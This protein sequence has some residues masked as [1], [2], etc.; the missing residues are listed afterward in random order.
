MNRRND[1]NFKHTFA[2]RILATI[3]GVISLM[4]GGIASPAG[5]TPGDVFTVATLANQSFPY[6]IA[7]DTSGN[8]YFTEPFY[9]VVR[10]ISS[11]GVVS[12]FAGT[13]AMGANDGPVGTATFNDPEGLAVDSSGNVYV[14]DSGNH[15]IRKI[16]TAGNVTT[17]SGTGAVGSNDGAF[18]VA[19]FEGPV[20][21][22]FDGNGNLIVTSNNRIRRIDPAGTVVTI[23]GTGGYGFT[24]GFALGAKFSSPTGV[25]VDGAGNVIIADLSNNRIRKL[26]PEGMVSTLAG[27]GVQNPTDGPGATASFK[28]PYGV[29]V[30]GGGTVYVSDRGNN[31]IR[32]VLPDGTV[33]S[34]AGSGAYGVDD[35]P[36]STATFSGLRGITLR[37]GN[38]FV[39][40]S[41]GD[42]IRRIEI[43]SDTIAPTVTLSSPTNGAT[44]AASPVITGNA[45]DNFGVTSVKVVV[46]RSL[47]GGGQFWNG[48]GWQTTYATAAATLA[49]PGALSTSWSYTLNGPT[50]GNFVVAAVALDASSNYSVSPF[51]T[52]AIED[53]T[54]PVAV[55]TSPTVA[56]SFS[57]KPV[58]IS[59]TSSDNAGVYQNNVVLSRSELGGQ[60][61]NGT[62]WQSTYV[63][64]VAETAGVGTTSTTWT[65]QFNPP[66]NGGTYYVAALTLDTNYNYDLTPFVGFSLVDTIAPTSTITAPAN[67]AA[68]TGPVTITGTANDNN[69]I[70]AV[71]VAV[72]RYSDATYWNGTTWQ[73]TFTTVNTTLGSPASSTTTFSTTIALGTPGYYLIATVPIDTNSNYSFNGWTTILHA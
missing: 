20:G 29:A 1:T 28:F 32:K 46:Y 12:T 56:Q 69:E 22:A 33:S 42:R 70:A 45:S 10:R 36:A 64:V 9:N 26:T 51:Q 7:S 59:G 73:A 66:Q 62:S 13:G 50:G 31:K 72:Y 48:G 53:T 57:T 43:P 54:N 4:V 14:A 25:A 15:K 16:D 37:N 55:I 44:V 60:Y 68:T 11:G 71:Q 65:Y 40:D 3:A 17:F 8:I 19:R 18:N 49:T 61:W 35:G 34:Y 5:A 30:D 52:F 38:L 6:A 2:W 39:A 24:D 27:N 21:M 63:A 23:A 58:T 47:P 41:Q 67:N